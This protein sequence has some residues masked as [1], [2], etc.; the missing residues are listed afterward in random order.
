MNTDLYFLKV[1]KPLLIFINKQH[2]MLKVALAKPQPGRLKMMITE[3]QF[4][5]LAENVLNEQFNKTIRN[6]HLI[7]V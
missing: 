2:I 6:T 5:R 4:L 1:L 7:R 3:S